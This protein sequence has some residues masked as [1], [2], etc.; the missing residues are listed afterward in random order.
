MDLDKKAPQLEHM[1]NF[2]DSGDEP[3]SFPLRVSE[4]EVE[5]IYLWAMALKHDIQW[6]V[7]LTFVA[8][9]KIEV[10]SIDNNGKPFRT[11]SSKNSTPYTLKNGQVVPGNPD[12]GM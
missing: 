2:T 1:T 9:G 4:T 6:T 3:W 10:L 5:V 12:M 8:D 7:E 11:V